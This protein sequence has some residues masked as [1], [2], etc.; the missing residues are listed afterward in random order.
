MQNKAY[1]E[2]KKLMDKC[3]NALENYKK[4]L[5]VKNGNVDY[6]LENFDEWLEWNY[7][8]FEN[9]FENWLEEFNIGDY[10]EYFQKYYDMPFCMF[11]SYDFVEYDEN[12]NPV[13]PD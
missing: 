11:Y 3:P 5:F 7:E 4:Y 1:E 6:I 9:E 13:E 10:T 8:N 2:F 12:G